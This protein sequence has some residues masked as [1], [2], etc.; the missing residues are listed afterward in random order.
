MDVRDCTSPTSQKI[1]VGMDTRV[2]WFGVLWCCLGL[3]LES[4]APARAQSAPVPLLQAEHPVDWWFVFK[5]NGASFPACG[6]AQRECLFGGTVQPYSS[7]GQQYVMA[8]SD[9]PSLAQGADCAGD[10]TADPIGATFDEIYNGDTF[11]VVWNDQFYDDPAI[12]G[13][14]KECGAPWGHSKGLLAWNGDGE[15]LV[16]QVTTPSWPAAGSKAHPRLSD[17]NTLGCVKDDDVEVSQHF[18]ALK[19]AKADVLVVL[20]SLANASVVTDLGNPQIVRN[21]GPPEIQALVQQLGAK[22]TSA[23]PLVSM[24]SNGVTVISKPSALHVPPWQMV[25]SLLGGVSLRTATWW[26]A[27]EIPSTAADAEI[28]C[29]DATL[30]PPGAVEI[31]TSGQWMGTDFGLTGGA[32]PNHNHAKIGV[33]LPGGAPYAIFGDMNQQGSPG[34]ATRPCGSSQNGRG[35]VFYALQNAQLADGVRSLISGDTAPGQS[36]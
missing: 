8:S 1:E 11:Y 25:S 26:T 36:Q 2:L 30:S 15:G 27:P 4:T 12:A 23:K 7:Y 19:L 32:S 14:T 21:G 6:G 34:P 10:T 17:G 3:L 31:A 18:F 9:N 16:V 35:G 20:S 29:W 5:F 13:C 24:L 33:A 28:G 22:S